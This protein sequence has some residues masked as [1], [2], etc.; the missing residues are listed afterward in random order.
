MSLMQRTLRRTSKWEK[1]D[2]RGELKYYIGMPT[3]LLSFFGSY[4]FLAKTL[5]GIAFVMGFFPLLKHD[6]VPIPNLS[7]NIL[8]FISTLAIIG[9]FGTLL[10]EVIHSIANFL[11]DVSEVLRRL[12][13]DIKTWVAHGTGFRLPLPS[14]ESLNQRRQEQDDDTKRTLRDEFRDF[15]MKFYS[16]QFNWWMNRLNEVSYVAR[17]H[18]TQFTRKLSSPASSF[19]HEHIIDFVRKDLDDSPPHNYDD[20]YMVVTSLLTNTGCE[21]AFRFQSRYAF[22]RS[23]AFVTLSIGVT[24]ITVIECP[25]F[26]PIP[27]ALNYEPYLLSYFSEGSNHGSI[28]GFISIL[29]III[30]IIFARA[31]GAYKRYFV[32]YLVAE[33]YVAREFLEDS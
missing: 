6:S 29:S 33:L 22:C 16:R 26:L 28:I 23:M 12:A 24:Y 5:P 7:E 8:I 18:R 21:R 17:G 30:S 11:E 1:S 10:G 3:R 31:A 20:I 14:E 25:T 2:I 4:D 19:A 27:S 13:Q 9:L 15:A 32:E